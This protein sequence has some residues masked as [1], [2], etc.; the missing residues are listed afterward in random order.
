MECPETINHSDGTKEKTVKRLEERR[1]GFVEMFKD[2]IQPDMNYYKEMLD[3]CE[4]SIEIPCK[5]VRVSSPFNSSAPTIEVQLSLILVKPSHHGDDG[6]GA[7]I[8]S[9]T[10]LSED[11]K[12]VSNRD[13]IIGGIYLQGEKDLFVNDGVENHKVELGDLNSEVLINLFEQVVHEQ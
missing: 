4:D 3:L 2:F 8:I 12:I 11:S 5:R 1:D 6:L 13:Q 9:G 10:L 7:L